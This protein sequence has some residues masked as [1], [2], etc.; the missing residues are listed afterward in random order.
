MKVDILFSGSRGNATLVRSGSTGI[1]IDSGKSARALCNAIR[2]IGADISCVGAVFI[3]HEHSDHTSA[4]DVLCKKNFFP[5]HAAGKSAH[6]L[7]ERNSI[8]NL[9]CHDEIY[10]ET[11]GDMTVKS[12]PVPHDSAGN[13]G[14]VITDKYG[15]TLGVATDIGHVT[16]TL[17]EHL[18]K[19]RRVIIESNHDVEMLKAGPYS[20]E[21][22]RR[23]LSPRGHLSNEECSLLACELADAGCEAFALA[24][25]SLDNNTPDI[26]YSETRRALDSSGHARCALALTYMES[27]TVLPDGLLAEEECGFEESICLK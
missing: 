17:R 20:A 23:I 25:I 7:K 15:D 27:H 12:F 4:L 8:N 19:C 26:A 22:K 10:E 5:V 11:V 13:V 9:V 21:L 24:H 1:L 16:D 3:T 2:E 14:Y 18:S 6:I